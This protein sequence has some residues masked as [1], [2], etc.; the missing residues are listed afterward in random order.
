ME[1]NKNT[2]CVNKKDY[3]RKSF[4][5]GILYGLIPHSFCIAFILFSV[6]GATV[7]TAFLKNF[8][9]IPHF[10]EFLLLISLLLAT[11]SSAIYLKKNECLCLAGAKSKWKY[12]TTLFSTT[13]L[14]NLLMF[15]V[16]LPALVNA[17]AKPQ[18]QINSKPSFK[19]QELKW[20]MSCSP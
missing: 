10:L 17:S 5:A 15:F 18:P 13:L 11:I 7:A 9:L 12:L 14:V 3:S 20:M 1:Q 4:L 16:I 8:M 2:C 19:M 6:V